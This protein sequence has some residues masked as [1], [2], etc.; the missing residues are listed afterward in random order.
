MCKKGYRCDFVALD[1]RRE[2]K[3]RHCVSF[4]GGGCRWMK[5]GKQTR[6]TV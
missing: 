4:N 2:K 3:R 1:N 5:N 6:F